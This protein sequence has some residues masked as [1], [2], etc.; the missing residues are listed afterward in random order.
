MV[1][2]GNM[3]LDRAH[4]HARWAERYDAQ[5]DTQRSV[6]HFG[7]AMHYA[8]MAQ[9]FGTSKRARDSRE[10]DS[11]DIVVG[12][13]EDGAEAWT[14]LYSET[15]R[16]RMQD[17][18]RGHGTTKRRRSPTGPIDSLYQVIP[19]M[20]ERLYTSERRGIT[21]SVH[22]D[23]TVQWYIHRCGTTGIVYLVP[24]PLEAGGSGTSIQAGVRSTVERA[25]RDPFAYTSTL[26]EG[27]LIVQDQSPGCVRVQRGGAWEHATK[28]ET[29]AY[30]DFLL[31]YPSSFRNYHFEKKAR[32]LDDALSKSRGPGVLKT[33]VKS[34]WTTV[35]SAYTTEQNE[36]LEITITR[37]GYDIFTGNRAAPASKKPD[38]ISDVAWR[39]PS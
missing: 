8:Q 15:R 19:S 12:R 25:A 35:P 34:L 9:A 39:L 7:R 14:A 36:D 4:A 23:P 32:E 31:R 26:Q 5:G 13:W 18:L 38:Q 10:A 17:V 24:A 21:D 29:F 22:G 3:P 2:A 27:L 1:R 37:V 20:L 28:F 30:Y 11:G 6:A 33:Q 16:S